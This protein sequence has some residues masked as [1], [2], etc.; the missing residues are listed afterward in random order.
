MILSS[1][2]SLTHLGFPN[3]CYVG[4]F[5]EARFL[6]L[7][8]QL[9]SDPISNPEAER[10]NDRD[11]HEPH[12]DPDVDGVAVGKHLHDPH[13]VATEMLRTFLVNGQWQCHKRNFHS[14]DKSY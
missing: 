11:L 14:G 6:N 1:Q 2:A 5:L 8:L 12:D 7:S 4:S 3:P 13:P 10:G 9:T